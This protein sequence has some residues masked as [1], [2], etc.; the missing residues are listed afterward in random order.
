MKSSGAQKK[1]NTFKNFETKS[2]VKS[3]YVQ[4]SMFKH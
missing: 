3:L 4:T 2:N 1:E